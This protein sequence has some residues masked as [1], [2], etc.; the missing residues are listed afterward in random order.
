MP[1]PERTDKM[2]HILKWLIARGKA[3]KLPKIL[4]AKRYIESEIC[5][6]GATPRTVNQYLLRLEANGHIRFD[7]LKIV[8]TQKGI[9][10]LQKK[11]S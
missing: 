11:V 5:S 10:W 4:E 7:G 6:M 8:C 3:K 1:Q 2:V 9:N